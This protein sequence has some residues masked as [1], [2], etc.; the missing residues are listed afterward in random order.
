MFECGGR[1]LLIEIPFMM[2][3]IL[4]GSDYNEVSLNHFLF[5]HLG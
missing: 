1:R 3:R 4:S 2:T 5:A